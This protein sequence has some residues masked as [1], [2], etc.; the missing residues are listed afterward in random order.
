[1]TRKNVGA[2]AVGHLVHVHDPENENLRWRVWRIEA[3]PSRRTARV[4]A[5][6]LG[7]SEVVDLFSLRP[8]EDA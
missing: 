2:F 3:F 8:L 7:T 5:E 4:M 6:D 1:M